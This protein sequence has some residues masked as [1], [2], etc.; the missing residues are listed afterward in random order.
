MIWCLSEYSPN[1]LIYSGLLYISKHR[2]EA[3]AT[4][5][6]TTNS[7]NDSLYLYLYFFLPNLPVFKKMLEIVVAA[8]WKI[9]KGWQRRAANHQTKLSY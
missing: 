6:K 1:L 7:S 8:A 3:K 5:T 4:V 2:R 9:Y